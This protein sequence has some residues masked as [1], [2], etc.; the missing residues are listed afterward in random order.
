MFPIIKNLG[1]NS[2]SSVSAKP[3]GNIFLLSSFQI[4]LTLLALYAFSS[5]FNRFS[6]S[7]YSF[8]L[9]VIGPYAAASPP[10]SAFSASL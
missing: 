1:D 10:P 7:I 8:D 6:S 2:T 5:L 3:G 4:L 9:M